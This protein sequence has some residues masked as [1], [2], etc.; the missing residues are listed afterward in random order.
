MTSWCL[1][2]LA[3][4]LARGG[5]THDVSSLSVRFPV[6]RQPASTPYRQRF[7]HFHQYVD[8]FVMLR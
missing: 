3:L 1:G 4:G 5:A 8:H 2:V 7:K 6:L